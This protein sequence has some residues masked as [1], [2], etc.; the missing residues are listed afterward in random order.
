M[1][2]QIALEARRKFDLLNGVI[3]MPT[4][5]C[6]QSDWIAINAM[7]VSWITNTIEPEVKFSIAKCEQTKNMSVSSYYGKLNALWEALDIHEPIISCSCCSEC[8]AGSIHETR[9]EQAKLHEFIMGLYSDYY[10]H[11]RTSILSQD[12]LPFLDRAYQ[13]VTQDERV[14]MAK[15][16]PGDQPHEA[17]G[18][19]V[20]TGMG[21]GRG[22]A[23]RP[24]CTQ[25]KKLGHDASQCLAHL[26]C[27]HCKK[28]GH[29]VNKCYEIVGYPNT[30]LESS[31]SDGGTGRGSRYSTFGQGRGTVRANAASGSSTS[32]AA[33]SSTTGNS[34]PQLFSAEQWKALAGLFGNAKVSE[35]RLSGKFDT[36]LWIIDTG[37]TH[38][39]TGNKSW[40]FDTHIFECHV[41]LP[42]GEI[43]VATLEGCVRLSDK[44]TLKHVLYVPQFHCNLLSVS[45][46]NDNLQCVVQFNSYMCAI[47]D[48]TNELIGT[49]VRRDGLYYFG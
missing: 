7:L 18:F 49:G 43:S 17:L 1:N 36:D 2:V 38:H 25:C 24:V 5:P 27:S 12:P 39:V 34:D 46:L 14:P 42:N 16:E 11:L 23:D 31:R 41:G 35:S 13:L 40:L 44:I 4:P 29:D 21:R 3:T 8:N 37:A 48:Q 45:Q 6:T 30:W 20:R 47:Q 9:R 19:T 15:F 32:V 22:R 26:I 33:V 10:A 28:H